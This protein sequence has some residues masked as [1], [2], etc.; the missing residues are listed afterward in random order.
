[1]K[2]IASNAALG[3]FLAQ[4]CN[5][6][7]AA[8]QEDA[9]ATV[10]RIM[11]YVAIAFVVVAVAGVYSMKGGDRRGDPLRKVYDKGE[12]IHS[13]A[14]DASVAECVRKMN[15]ERIGALVVVEG[16]RL[17]GIF[18]ERDALKKVLAAEMDP[19]TT[20]VSQVMTRDPV[21]VAPATTVGDA[22][23]L[24]TTRRFRHLPVVQDGALL[25]V[26]SSGDLTNWLMQDQIRE[27]Q[28]LAASAFAP[29]RAY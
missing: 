4:L 14:P 20:K 29:D 22:M 15:A 27:T 7:L 24:I 12:S 3:F 2:R 6:A 21:C 16:P 23:E 19:R 11:L 1:M 26:L 17:V 28:S 18:T 25:A 10:T 13:V 5:A 8:S 9:M